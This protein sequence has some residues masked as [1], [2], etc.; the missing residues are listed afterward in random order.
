MIRI[1]PDWKSV[2]KTQI[3]NDGMEL[4][5]A[6]LV[7]SHVW[8]YRCH[9]EFDELYNNYSSLNELRDATDI[10]L[11]TIASVDIEDDQDVRRDMLGII[12]VTEDDL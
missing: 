5:A 12:G 8:V 6:L 4:T 11:R 9:I 7:G 2:V 3:S 10:D 1:S